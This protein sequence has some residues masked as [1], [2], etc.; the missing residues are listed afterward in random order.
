MRYLLLCFFLCLS[1][2]IQAQSAKKVLAFARA[3]I[4]TLCSETFAGR[5]YIN[6]GHLKAATYIASRF[7]ELGAESF[8]EQAAMGVERY[9]QPFEFEINLVRKTSLLLNGQ[10]MTPGLDFIVNAYSGS[11][12]QSGKVVDLK[13]GLKAKAS[14]KGK[15]VLFRAGW[16]ASI[17]NDSDKRDT[18]KELSRVDQRIAAILPYG[19]AA[20]IVV[21]P[22]LTASFARENLPLPIIEVRAESISGKVKKAALVVQAGME[23]I[24]SQNVICQVRGTEQPDSVVIVSAHYDHLGMLGE[25]RFPGANDN[26]SGTSMLLSMVEYF[27][28]KPQRYTMM[29]IAFGGEE[30]GLIGSNYYVNRDPIVALKQTRF[31]LNLDL[32]GN[33]VDGITAVGGRDFPDLFDDLVALNDKMKAVPK[34]KSRSNAPNSD[35]YF[36]L[37]RGVQGFFI[38]TLG[39]P[40]HYHDINDNPDTIVLSKYVEVRKLLIRF[41]ELLNG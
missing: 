12:M 13:Y 35:H 38:Y 21:Q 4:D 37:E 7:E 3:E 14:I 17:A 5:G 16:P 34:V 33:G 29:F 32:M 27:V 11:G 31:I 41:L 26:A 6:D 18:Y 40:P 25:S 1:I 36:F 28:D 9:F 2:S 19:P 24:R 15:I 20:I 8:R 30:T 39:G 23:K 10:E 22:K